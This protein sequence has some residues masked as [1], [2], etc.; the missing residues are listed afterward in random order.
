[1]HFP[2]LATQ[3]PFYLVLFTNT[4]AI[5]PCVILPLLL[6]RKVASW[7]F[8]N[9]YNF[10]RLWKKEYN[11]FNAEILLYLNFMSKQLNL[12]LLKD[13]MYCCQGPQ[14]LFFSE[15]VIHSIFLRILFNENYVLRKKIV[16]R[17]FF[18]L[19]KNENKI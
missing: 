3:H 17:Y 1:V 7:H 6:R 14:T 19:T 18:H 13:V 11:V 5:V 15:N 4:C 9:F 16:F 12:F 10:I 2:Y 8:F